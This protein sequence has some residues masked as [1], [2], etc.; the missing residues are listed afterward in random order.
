MTVSDNQVW[1]VFGSGSCLDTQAQ[2]AGRIVISDEFLMKI[3]LKRQQRHSP[4]Y[5]DN[6][7]FK[8]L[9][10]RPGKKSMS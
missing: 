3:N 10:S 4:I 9:I 7:V 1:Y 6:I 2:M 8:L 5:P